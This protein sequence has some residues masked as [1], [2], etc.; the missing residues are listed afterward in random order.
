[1]FLNRQFAPPGG[2]LFRF[3]TFRS[4]AAAIT[5][6][7]ISFIVGPAILRTLVRRGIVSTAREGAPEKHKAKA[8]TPMM[9]GIIILCAVLIPTLLWA[10]IANMYVILVLFATLTLGLVGFYDDYLKVVKRYGPGLIARYKLG[11]QIFVGA[12]V[13][14]TIYFAPHLAGYASTTTVPFLKHFEFD[15]YWLY[16]PFVIMVI[17]ATSNA[18]N[19]TDGLDGLAIG[20][21]GV[22][23]LAFALISYATGNE[24]FSSYLNIRFLYGTGELTVFC[25]SL[26]GASLGFLWFN[27][28]P[29]QVF[30]G[31]TGSLALGG[32]VGTLAV[33]VK[34]EFILP[35]VGGIFFLEAVSVILQTTYFKYTK[36]KYGAGRRI[37]R[38]APL[39][40]HFEMLGWTEPK[41][42][43]RFYII[44]VMLAII[45]LTTFKVR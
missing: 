36:K 32:A 31:D 38:M 19:L 15:F 41:I 1:M 33:L 30:M 26:V 21:V 12:V 3:I 6:L 17:T 16:I 14:A 8:G 45:S 28:Y 29:A 34:K 10:D 24:I 11:G 40:H 37:F 5:A 4:A 18:V 9:G 2:N 25:A 13:G 39:H 44:A 27:A 7:V 42:V 22:V 23:A 43:V 20:T 35:I